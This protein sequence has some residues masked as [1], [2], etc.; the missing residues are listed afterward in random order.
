MR[1]SRHQVIEV[2]LT[3]SDLVDQQGENY[4]SSGHINL[5]TPPVLRFLLK[6]EGLEVLC[7]HTTIYPTELAAHF[8]EQT[9]NAP[10]S[11][12]KPPVQR[13]QHLWRSAFF[14]PGGSRNRERQADTY[15]VLTQASQRLHIVG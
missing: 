10:V 5:Y 12:F 9:D 2:P 7:G 13:L 1:V 14:H 15:T 11:S 8:A 4:L 3:R 6:S